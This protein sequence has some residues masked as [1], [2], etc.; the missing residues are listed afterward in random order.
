MSKS[1]Q[2]DAYLVALVLLAISIPLSKFGMS[3]A[4]FMLLYIWL[5]D[6][7]GYKNIKTLFLES[8]GIQKLLKPISYF[9][10][11]LAK[12]FISKTKVFLTNKIAVLV[13]SLFLLHL[14]GLVHTTDFAY[15]LKDLRTKIPLLLLPLIFSSMPALN[16]RKTNILLIFYILAVFAGSMFSIFTYLKQ[17]FSDIRQISIFISSVRFSL[18][19]VF[20]FFLIIYFLKNHH[21]LPLWLTLLM[22]AAA[23]WFVSFIILLES[24]I[25][26]LSLV[27]ISA[28]LLLWLALNMTRPSVRV[29][30]IVF[31]IG[32]PA[33]FIYHIGSISKALMIPEKVDWETLDK[34]TVAG[35]PYVHD[36][37]NFIIE[38]GHY[39]GLY[40]AEEE[41]AEA[42][43][44]RSE[45]EFYGQDEAGHYIK[46]TII[47]YLASKDLRK[48]A[49]GVAELSEKDIRHIEK[50]IANMHYI[51][52]PGIRTR[53]SKIL[54]GY[55]QYANRNDP[56]GSS[57]MQRIEFVK[58]S[59]VLI[60]E[61][62]WIGVGTGDLPQAFKSAYEQ[63]DSPL[64]DK[65]R[66]RSHNQYLSIFIAFGVF[67]FLWFMFILFYPTFYQKRYLDYRYF[68]FISIILLSMLS[69][70]TIESQAGLTL[71]AFFN[72]FFLL[73]CR[74]QHI[75]DNSIKRSN[76]S[77]K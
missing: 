37:I 68:V 40:I 18:S 32:I 19:I 48:D 66:W 15:A 36:T 63:T 8:S 59:L 74:G 51:E 2:I 9:F 57:V 20:S 72:S 27:V 69:E 58:T 31:L 1:Q 38:D 77:K 76:K 73:A 42:W 64:Q 7:I 71:Y 54:M 43:N 55:Y 60:K 62:F 14:I 17:D 56:N 52:N 67:G 45:F 46:H 75:A 44:R 3:V 16:K 50:G 41:L 33:A 5:T 28:L 35:N 61:N 49:E 12:N 24:A 6:G 47:R 70:D 21:P 39:T 25:G 22:V 53:I 13:A 34:F 4:Q 30:L 65:W 11:Y 10:G 26:L 29:L 23:I